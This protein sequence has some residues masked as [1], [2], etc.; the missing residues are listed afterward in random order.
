MVKSQATPKGLDEKSF[1]NPDGEVA[2]KRLS[3]WPEYRFS[4]RTSPSHS[5]S[6][7]STPNLRSWFEPTNCV[8]ATLNCCRGYSFVP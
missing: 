5:T 3:P 7:A 4:R 8:T 6:C 2:L 1:T